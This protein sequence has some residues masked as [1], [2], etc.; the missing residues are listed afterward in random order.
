MC[1][2]ISFFLNQVKFH[3]ETCS[4]SAKLQNTGPLA[5][6]SLNHKGAWHFVRAIFAYTVMAH[7][8]QV[9]RSGPAF[10]SCSLD[11]TGIRVFKAN[12]VYETHE[13]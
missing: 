2:S 11:S 8:K 12:V 4:V 13:T 7:V 3:E 9:L 6:I 5:Y 10:C 1:R